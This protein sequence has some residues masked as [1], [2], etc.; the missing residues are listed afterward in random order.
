MHYDLNKNEELKDV[1]KNVQ[2][3]IADLFNIETKTFITCWKCSFI[4]E[5]KEN[6]FF[7]PIPLSPQNNELFNCFRKLFE[8]ESMEMSCPDCHESSLSKNTRISKLPHTLILHFQRFQFTGV[9]FKKYNEK[10]DFPLTLFDLNDFTV[11]HARKYYELYAVCNH[12]GTRNYGHYWTYAKVKDHDNKWFSFNDAT[13][14]E[15]KESE[16]LSNSS[17]ILFY[18]EK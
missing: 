10:I 16:V 3:K 17:Y 12:S 9:T 1:K 5:K 13:V 18:R 6:S 8:T 15:I 2:S 7:L 4:H 14:T 11:E